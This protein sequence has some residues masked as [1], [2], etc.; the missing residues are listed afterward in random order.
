MDYVAHVVIVFL[1][2]AILAI[3]LNL[4][5][6][7]S[8]LLSLAHAAFFGVGAY[9]SALMVIHL[10]VNFFVAMFVGI[11]IAAIMGAIVSIPALRVRAEYLILLTLGFQKVIY[12]LMVT[13]E[14]LTKGTT[15]LSNI[16]RPKI[17]ELGFVSPPSYLPLVFA[18]SG[19]SFAIVWRITHSPFGRVLKAMREDEEL[20]VSFGKDVLWF[21]VLAFIV[22]GS[23]AA[24]SGS[25][26]ASYTTFI[27]PQYFTVDVSIF[28]I[29][30]V[31]L[32]GR[33]NLWGSVVGAFLLITIPE[34][35]TFVGGEHELVD[36]VRAASYGALLVLF[37]RFRPQGMVPE[38]A[39]VRRG[40]SSAHDSLSP[41]EKDKILSCRDG[42]DRKSKENGKDQDLPIEIKGL[43]K[44]FGGL[45]A[46]D[47]LTLSLPEHRIT[48]LIGPNGAG[49]TTAFNL[50]TNFLKADKGSVYY[51]GLDIT[52]VSPHR[53]A[54]LGVVRSFQGSRV[55]NGMSVLDCVL[56]ACPK[57]S[58]ESLRSLLFLPWKIARE[59]NENR[60]SAMVCLK[61]VGLGEKAQELAG[62]LSYAEQKMLQLACLLA[63]KPEVLLLDEPVSGVD[64]RSIDHVLT[65]I[66]QL[67][68]HGKTVCIIEHNL[69]VVKNLA[70]SAYFLDQGQVVTEGT[71]LDLMNASNLV[72]RYFGV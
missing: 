56:L 35:L 47:N 27:S 26:F 59:E 6:G 33:A 37:M 42:T 1:I 53:I 51:R 48:A 67:I 58:G 46:V 18:L 10:G 11:L 24:V 3:S 2:Y 9:A 62:E 16:A 17:F 54:R 39:G 32:G 36:S 45:R 29:A 52:N 68:D 69:D 30:I 38:H 15:G 20:A 23:I 13:L 71:P 49:K 14:D 7:Y 60:K 65:L 22:A 28:I 8:G 5:L 21:K 25:L 44:N 55:F 43:C 31:A 41:G 63:T 64:P 70:D 57:Q 40:S 19:L 72:E 66:R 4:L 34:G 50:I 12:G 61:F